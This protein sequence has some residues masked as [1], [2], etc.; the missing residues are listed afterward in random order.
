MASCTHITLIQINIKCTANDFLTW[1]LVITNELFRSYLENREEKTF[2]SLGRSIDRCCLPPVPV[3][4]LLAGTSLVNVDGAWIHTHCAYLSSFA[5]SH[6][7]RHTDERAVLFLMDVLS[8]EVKEV[9][10]L[11]AGKAKSKT[12]GNK[13]DTKQGRSL[14][15]FARYYDFVI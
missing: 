1:H 5:S 3:I 2:A 9:E 14:Y 6:N 11:K 10:A 15:T 4:Y 8:S 12:W 13:D 7:E